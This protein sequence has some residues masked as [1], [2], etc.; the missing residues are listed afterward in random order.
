MFVLLIRRICT[1]EAKPRAQCSVN[2]SYVN[3]KESTGTWSNQNI[4]L[5]KYKLWTRTVI[6]YKSLT[7]V[8][9]ILLS[10]FILSILSYYK[11]LSNYHSFLFHVIFYHRNL[12]ENCLSEI[13]YLCYLSSTTWIKHLSLWVLTRTSNSLTLLRSGLLIN[14]HGRGGG[15]P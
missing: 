14:D 4:S 11:P 2:W 6:V 3:I 9:R 1:R 13:T 8:Q 5:V 15:G 12:P 7:T 10:K